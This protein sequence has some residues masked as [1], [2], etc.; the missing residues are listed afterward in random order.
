MSH[1]FVTMWCAANPAASND[2]AATPMAT[3]N[4]ACNNT[5][6]DHM[7]NPSRTKSNASRI[8][9]DFAPKTSSGAEYAWWFSSSLVRIR[10]VNVV[11][12]T[13][14]ATTAT[15]YPTPATRMTRSAS[16]PPTTNATTT[17][18]VSLA[19]LPI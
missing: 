19:A 9:K 3:R 13:A 16:A 7:D 8:A 15:R 17:A 2:L 10:S 5:D 18:K 6:R 12:T 14:C 1:K 11:P 4:D